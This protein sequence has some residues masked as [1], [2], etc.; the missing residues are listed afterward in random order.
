MSGGPSRPASPTKL[1]FSKGLQ[2]ELSE[3]G[4]F[5]L[6]KLHYS[7]TKL[8]A[9]DHSPLL[10]VGLWSLIEC[11]TNLDGRNPQT[12]FV[13]YLN[14]KRLEDM[15][16]GGRQATKSMRDALTRISE[17]GNGTKHDG[18]AAGFNYEQL[19]NDFQ[20]VEKLL[21]KLVKNCIAKKAN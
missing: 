17:F 13:S 10:F 7:L 3:L 8:S 5:K 9:K 1:P 18:E 14:S 15:G 21:K 12:D 19:V 6:R 16:F 4:N 2:D 20:V 11:L